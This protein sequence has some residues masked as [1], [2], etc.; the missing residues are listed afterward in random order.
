M[1]AAWGRRANGVGNKTLD[2]KIAQYSVQR[3]KGGEGPRKTGFWLQQLS[4]QC[5]SLGW[6]SRRKGLDRHHK[7]VFPPIVQMR[8]LRLREQ[9]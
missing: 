8:K 2:F 7:T 4:K 5:L 3:E 6:K 9:K 1:R